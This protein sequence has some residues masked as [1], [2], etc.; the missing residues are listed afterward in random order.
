MVT[1]LMTVAEF[2]KIAEADDN[3]R[4]ELIHGEIIEKMPT[5]LHAYIIAL[6]TTAIMNHLTDHP[7]GKVLVEARY[8]IPD[9]QH[10]ARIID[11]SFITHEKGTLVEEGAAPYMPDLAV[12]VQSPGQTEK[13][14]LEKARYYLANGTDTVWLIYPK[15]QIVEVLTTTERHLLVAADTLN[16][17]DVLPGFAL[18]IDRLFE[19]QK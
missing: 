16:G 3:R 15:K 10:N 5:Q 6:L 11:L 7:I 13:L 18:Q 12:E 1:R 17:G 2:E 4:L 8:H 19:Q 14:M 9:D